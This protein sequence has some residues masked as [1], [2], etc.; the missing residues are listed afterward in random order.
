MT[1]FHPFYVF[2]ELFLCVL[3]FL[4]VTSL[5]ISILLLAYS[6]QD[7]RINMHNW[8]YL[9]NPILNKNQFLPNAEIKTLNIKRICL[10]SAHKSTHVLYSRLWIL[11]YFDQ[12]NCFTLSHWK[13]SANE[14]FWHFFKVKSKRYLKWYQFGDMIKAII[15]TS[16]FCDISCLFS[17][18]KVFMH[19]FIT[20]QGY[21]CQ[22]P[23]ITNLL[24]YISPSSVWLKPA[25]LHLWTNIHICWELRGRWYHFWLVSLNSLWVFLASPRLVCF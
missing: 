17:F 18:K 21:L 2:V 5:W 1:Y 25:F 19:M 15:K 3:L 12:Y 23:A 6:T 13:W 7:H 4:K 20:R 8:P 14:K 24:C 11:C 9:N 16:I 22:G 10:P